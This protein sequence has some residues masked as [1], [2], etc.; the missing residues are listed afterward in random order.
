VYYL[1]Y[2]DFY[3]S[4]KFQQQVSFLG[5]HLTF[6]D[7]SAIHYSLNMAN[8]RFN[9]GGKWGNISPTYVCS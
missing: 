5:G 3:V 4:F 8:L 7:L 1:F 2:K 6:V 9:L